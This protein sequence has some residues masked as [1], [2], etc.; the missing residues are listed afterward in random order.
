MATLR[1]QRLTL[2]GRR[3]NATVALFVFPLERVMPNLTS[4]FLRSSSLVAIDLGVA[5]NSAHR[6]GRPAD[7]ISPAKMLGVGARG[8]VLGIRVLRV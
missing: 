3:A 6:A 2:I 4:S 1:R 7:I 5:L 8:F